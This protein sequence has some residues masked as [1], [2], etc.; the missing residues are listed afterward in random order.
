MNTQPI[1]SKLAITFALLFPF[2]LVTLFDLLGV[3]QSDD[4]FD[5][6]PLLLLASILIGI[7]IAVISTWKNRTGIRPALGLSLFTSF[8]IVWMNAAVGIIGSEDNR[9][10]IIYYGLVSF[11]I[12]WVMIENYTLLGFARSMF[13]S[14]I[15]TVLLGVSV[16]IAAGMNG[17]SLI[18]L[19]QIAVLNGI[20]A[21]LYGISALL[22][23][24][25]AQNIT[26]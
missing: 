21:V 24:K 6:L 19:I 4:F 15:V 10:N 13:A 12:I 14:M 25:S 1:K 26:N 11:S 18:G 2:I 16:M 8:L 23:R 3:I 5:R 20:F 9:I 22:F 7:V 17:V